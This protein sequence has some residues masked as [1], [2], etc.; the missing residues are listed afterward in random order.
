MSDPSSSQRT[1]FILSDATGDTASR[2]VRAALKQFMSEGLAIRRFPNVL[3][4][5]EVR[6]IVEEARKQ[7]TIVAHTFASSA[8]REVVEEVAADTG[9]RTLDLLGPL[10]TTLQDF[11]RSDPKGT[12][13]L[14]H[15]INADYFR[16]ID[17]VE[18]AVM[19]DDGKHQ[20]G[21]E[22]ADIVLV[23]LSRTGKT[24]LSVYL[25]LEGWRVANVPLVGERPIPAQVLDV[26]RERLVGLI[27]DP[28]RLTEIRR[29]RLSYIAPGTRMAYDDEASVREEIAWCRREFGRRRI[30]MID[31]TQKAIEESAHEV[32]SYVKRATGGQISSDPSRDRLRA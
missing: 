6:S 23:G 2:I 22:H 16:K 20:E 26:P 12:P 13:G 17:A 3:R 14:F 19:H 29:S 7:P 21:L 11:L 5:S 8:L 15:E 4:N 9:V 32:L 24:P 27:I 10:L 28:R 25:A 30:K 1:V 18:F 31:V